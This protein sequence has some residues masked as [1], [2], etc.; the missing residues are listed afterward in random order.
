VHSEAAALVAQLVHRTGANLH[1]ARAI[2]SPY[3]ICPLGAHID[4]QGG[5][6]LGMTI[7]AYALLA[8]V[9]CTEPRIRLESLN[10]PGVVEFDARAIPPSFRATGAIIRGALSA[11]CGTTMTSAAAS[12]ALSRAHCPAAA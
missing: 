10:F 8:Y 11:H 9:P 3:R 12:P 7:N 4:H 2:A 5:P 1:V 6:V